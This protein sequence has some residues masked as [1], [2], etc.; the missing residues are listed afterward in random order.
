MIKSLFFPRYPEGIGQ[1]SKLKMA[2]RFSMYIFLYTVYT[3]LL[4]A[5]HFSKSLFS[6]NRMFCGNG[7]VDFVTDGIPDQ[8]GKSCT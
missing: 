2:R 8:D 6:K 1:N 3:E 5:I 7:K 4:K